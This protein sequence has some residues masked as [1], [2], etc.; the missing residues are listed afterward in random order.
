MNSYKSIASMVAVALVCLTTTA[1]A[2]E[3]RQLM[4]YVETG[5][6]NAET[7]AGVDSL[8][9]DFIHSWATQ[10]VAAHMALFSEDAEWINAYARMFRG[11]H[12]LSIFLEQRLLVSEERLQS[13]VNP[14]GERT[15]TWWLKRDKVIG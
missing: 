14:C 12:E 1:F 10:D 5:S 3:R 2:A 9:E 6:P 4:E 15:C 13:A 11:K 7:R 8:L